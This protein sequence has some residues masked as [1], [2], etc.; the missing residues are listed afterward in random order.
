[1]VQL[2]AEMEKFDQAAVAIVT[3]TKN[4]GDAI[5]RSTPLIIASLNIV[6]VEP[7]ALRKKARTIVSDQVYI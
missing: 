2:I 6:F 3:T 1:M 4:A 7:L 5:G